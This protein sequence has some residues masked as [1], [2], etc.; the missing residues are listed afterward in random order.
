M[1]NVEST[2]MPLLVNNHTR[3]THVPST[4]DHDDVTLVELDVVDDFVL[5]KVELDSVVDLDGRVGVS[6]GSAVVGHNVGDALGTEL[7]F[8]DLEELEGSLLGGDAVDG[9]AS[10]DVVEETEVLAGSLNGDDV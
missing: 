5:D 6:N 1:N 8:T 2:Q 9:E 10:L 3:S 7:M 4:S